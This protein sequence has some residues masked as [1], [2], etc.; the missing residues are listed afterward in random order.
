MCQYIESA[1]DAC[2]LDLQFVFIIAAVIIIITITIIVVFSVIAIIVITV[3]SV[4][5]VCF[6]ASQHDDRQEAQERQAQAEEEAGLAL[7]T[8]QAGMKLTLTQKVPSCLANVAHHELESEFFVIIIIVVVVVV[9]IVIIIIVII[10]III[11]II[12]VAHVTTFMHKD[13]I[14]HT[15]R[16]EHLVGATLQQRCNTTLIPVMCLHKTKPK[17]AWLAV[18]LPASN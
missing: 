16:V 18:F 13:C 11:I 8:R 6:T 12:T 5:M 17:H 9:V 2:W 4:N 15:T 3:N 14:M 10:I 7:L 1:L